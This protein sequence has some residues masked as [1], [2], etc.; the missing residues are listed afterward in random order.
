MTRRVTAIAVGVRGT[1]R[2][3]Q[4]IRF[5]GM[6]TSFHCP[7]CLRPSALGDDTPFSLCQYCGYDLN[8]YQCDGC[9]AISISRSVGPRYACLVCH[10]KVRKNGA[11]Y[12]LW[13]IP[14]FQELALET[15]KRFEGKDADAIP[16]LTRLGPFTVVDGAGWAPRI[17][18]SALI[19]VGDA[20]FHIGDVDVALTDIIDLQV[21]G[22]S[23]VTG[24]GFFGGGFG[25]QAAGEGML[26]AQL[27]NRVTTK[28]HNFVVFSIV[29]K[30]GRVVGQVDG[31]SSQQVRNILRPILDEA[32]SAS[33]GD[34]QASAVS[35]DLQ[36]LSMQLERLGA[37]R[38]SGVL[39]E[40][41]FDAAKKKVLGL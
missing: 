27:L 13:N 4:Y 24:G 25:L 14:A 41:E 6:G 26:A 15:S 19:T 34:H 1:G 39:S 23:L 35:S 22:R 11:A 38:Q 8:G 37:L 29:G 3:R 9:A 32:L 21:E 20:T 16:K 10:K 17:G 30:T 40:H 28:R 7:N 36:D 5:M 33:A 12:P 2:I 18:S 31:V